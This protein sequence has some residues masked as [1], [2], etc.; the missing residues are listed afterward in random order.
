MVLIFIDNVLKTNELEPLDFFKLIL[1]RQLALTSL[2]H[3]SV[4]FTCLEWIFINEFRFCFKVLLLLIYIFNYFELPRLNQVD[5]GNK[6]AFPKQIGAPYLD[7]RLE[8]IY[9]NS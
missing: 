6:V 9:D 8:L 4:L 3:Q 7:K 2:S 1:L 5:V